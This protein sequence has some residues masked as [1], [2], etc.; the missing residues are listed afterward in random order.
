MSRLLPTPLPFFTVD[1]EL[2]EAQNRLRRFLGK[3]FGFEPIPL[4]E[5]LGW[6]PK[7]EIIENELDLVLTAE[8]PG[9]LQENVDITFENGLLTIAGEKKEEREEKQEKEKNG[10]PRFH[11]WERAYGEF[12]R[13]FTLPQDIDPE[14]IVAQ[15]K[16]GVLTITMPKTVLPK[17]KGR[18]IQIAGAK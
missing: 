3:E 15:M 2:T 11:L 9:M 6:I 10:S 8:L 5:P 16:D 4:M 1:R 17:E 14:K 7:V 18:K 13:T 12:R